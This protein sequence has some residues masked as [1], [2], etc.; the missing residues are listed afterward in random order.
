MKAEPAR[1]LRPTAH[2]EV[3]L[4]GQGYGS[5][6]GIDEAGRGPLAGPVVAAAV[7]FSPG[8]SAPWLS[9]V[10]DSKQLTP[11][12]RSELYQRLHSEALAIGVGSSSA[13][14]IDRVG[15]LKATQLAMTRAV[16]D[17]RPRP[18]YLLIDYVRL[19]GLAIPQLSLVKG[20]ARCLSI[21]AASIIAKVTRDRLLEQLDLQYPGYGF[22]VHK[23]YPTPQH[24]ANLQRLGPCPIHRTSFLP[25]RQLLEGLPGL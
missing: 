20:D 5:I 4:H 8:F 17:L 1:G 12:L 2:L 23:G 9:Q 7:I 6:A 25:V 19:P 14:Q 21:A 15:I 10:N 18:D 13:D 11:T 22:A 16:Q 3:S 24:L